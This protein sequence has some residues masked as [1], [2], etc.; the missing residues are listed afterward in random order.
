MHSQEWPQ[1]LLQTQL[2]TP[3]QYVQQDHLQYLHL[4][5]MQPQNHPSQHGNSWLQVGGCQDDIVG[6]VVRGSYSLHS[7][8]HGKP[9]YKKT[10]QVR[11]LDVLIYFWDE[12]NGTSYSGWWFGPVIG[13]DEVWAYNRDTTCMMPPSYGWQVP[14]DG[15]VD[16]FFQLT[17]ILSQADLGRPAEEMTVVQA[18]NIAEHKA[19]T[20]PP[21][22]TADLAECKVVVPPPKVRAESTEGKVMV[23]PP[24]ARAEPTEGKAMVPPPKVTAEPSRFWNANVRAPNRLDSPTHSKVTQ[25]AA[26]HVS[27]PKMDQ[28]VQDVKRAAEDMVGVMV[29]PPKVV[30]GVK[31][32]LGDLADMTVVP[33]KVAR[34]GEDREQDMDWQPKERHAA[35][36]IRDVI[37]RVRSCTPETLDARKKL[38]EETMEQNLAS[39]GGQVRKELN[40]EARAACSFADQ[41][42]A[43]M[44][45]LLRSSKE[46]SASLKIRQVIQR[47]RSAIPETFNMFKILSFKN[48][49]EESISQNL[50]ECGSLITKLKAEAQEVQDVANQRVMEINKKQRKSEE[51]GQTHGAVAEKA[52]TVHSANCK[53]RNSEASDDEKR[54]RDQQFR[55]A[56]EQMKKEAEEKIRLPLD[57]EALE[58]EHKAMAGTKETKNQKSMGPTDFK[59]PAEEETTSKKLLHKRNE[60][61][62]MMLKNVEDK[63][64]KEKEERKCLL[65]EVPLREHEGVA[66]KRADENKMKEQLQDHDNGKE[67]HQKHEEVQEHRREEGEETTEIVKMTDADEAEKQKPEQKRNVNAKEETPGKVMSV[68]PYVKVIECPEETRQSLFEL[69]ITHGW[70]RDEDEECRE[71][72]HKLL[73]L[74][75]DPSKATPC[76]YVS[77]V[78][79]DEDFLVGAAILRMQLYRDRRR[80]GKLMYIV[81]VQRGAGKL[82]I[83]SA[84]IFLKAHG[85]LRFFSAADL[86]RESD[87]ETE[88]LSALEAHKRWGFKRC[89]RQVWMDAGLK[90]YKKNCDVEYMMMEVDPSR[91]DTASAS[92]VASAPQARVK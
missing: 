17:M 72:L 22:S 83:R 45:E 26:M 73:Y 3:D 44:N 14:Y 84:H 39:C 25:S 29:V 48:E 53:G 68:A 35:L 50:A 37:Q 91:Y 74:G 57:Q 71:Y 87:D 58:R 19:V 66:T 47:I 6:G 32:P 49:L 8:N 65:A 23:P 56:G 60:D 16:P 90:P 42:S 85:V 43:S 11:G 76:I 1:Q 89:E 2:K 41:K 80:C 55:E 69:F 54:R 34:V 4:N 52:T 24:K 20:P 18:P 21:R 28:V 62:D 77:W 38:L 15:P 78:T 92:H 46:K 27:E 51:R 59:C 88:T 33:A 86:S 12:G 31:R 63:L 79:N 82:L 70:D 7:Q 61:Q 5:Q 67:E 9:V 81:S 64:Q 36:K 13:G 30:E 40:E 75:S 10:E